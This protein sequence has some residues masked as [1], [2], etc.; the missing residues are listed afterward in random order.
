[1]NPIYT[2]GNSIWYNLKNGYAETMYVNRHPYFNNNRN[3]DNIYKKNNIIYYYLDCSG[4][5]RFILNSIDNKLLYEFYQISPYLDYYNNNIIQYPRS[6]TF[7]T[8]FSD[9]EYKKYDSYTSSFILYLRNS[10][11]N[12][13]WFFSKPNKYLNNLIPGD[14]LVR[15]YDKSTNTGH[16]G[17]VLSIDSDKNGNYANVLESTKSNKKYRNLNQ[18]IMNINYSTNNKIRM[19]DLKNIKIVSIKDL[20]KHLF[21]YKNENLINSSLYNKI[22]IK[23]LRSIA[24]HLST[25]GGIQ[26]SKWRWNKIKNYVYGR[27]PTRYNI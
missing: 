11:L 3:I 21:L 9:N 1:M 19:Y 6:I 7:Y 14:I 12:K 10:L 17:I 22:E 13:G 2:L 5:V 16:M 8:L 23:N 20:R 27:I 15:K 18:L 24:A 25:N 26:C 4:L